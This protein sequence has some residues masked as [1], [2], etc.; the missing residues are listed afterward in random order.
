MTCMDSGL[1]IL[2]LALIL[3][4]LCD[5]ANYLTY[6]PFSFS[7]HKMG[8]MVPLLQKDHVMYYFYNRVKNVAAYTKQDA[9]HLMKNT[10][11]CMKSV[12]TGV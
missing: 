11:T 10:V 2:W 9:F 4:Q 6:L 12:V 3:T 1:H 7:T 5:K 8:K